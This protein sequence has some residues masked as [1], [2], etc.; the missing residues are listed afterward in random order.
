V[1]NPPD[2]D[3]T[4]VSSSKSRISKVTE[5]PYNPLSVPPI[6]IP[7]IEDYPISHLSENS[8]LFACP[9]TNQHKLNLRLRPIPYQNARRSPRQPHQHRGAR[10]ACPALEEDPRGGHFQ[11]DDVFS[12]RR[13]DREDWR[14]VRCFDQFLFCVRRVSGCVRLSIRGMVSFRKGLAKADVGRLRLYLDS[15]GGVQG[16]EREQC[17]VNYVVILGFKDIL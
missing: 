11:Q 1:V 10:Q 14:S 12:F 16:A 17:S 2:Q 5:K 9:H 15:W 8:L 3:K 7:T 6:F 13:G 4:I